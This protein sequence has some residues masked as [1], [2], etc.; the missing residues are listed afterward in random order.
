MNNNK[1][2]WL[3]ILLIFSV[4][5][6]ITTI[7]INQILIKNKEIQNKKQEETLVTITNEVTERLGN[8]FVNT[9][10]IVESNTEIESITF[11]NEDGTNI[12]V[13]TSKLKVAKD[14]RAKLEKEY[15]I[16]VVTKNGIVT[17]KILKIETTIAD[18][19]KVGDFINY[20]VGNWTNADIDLLGNLYSGTSF[21]KKCMNFGGFGVGI[22]KDSSIY[23]TTYKTGWRILSTNSDGS[24]NIMHAGLP[25]SYCWEASNSWDDTDG[26][27]AETL[28]RNTYFKM[29]EDCS[30][31]SVSTQ[32]AIPN[33]AH[34]ITLAEVQSLPENLRA[35]GCPYFLPQKSGDNGRGLYVHS[36]GR[37]YA[38][39]RE[40]YG[41]RVVV[42]LKSNVK[43]LI[44]ENQT[45]HSTP[46]TAW[47]L[48]LS[49]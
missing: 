30:S 26:R 38:I 8:G 3:C 24:V 40:S 28:K 25:M 23:N 11:P 15:P 39:N 16:T 48:N 44:V 21:P 41:I 43:P 46:E 42:M 35:V 13:S 22:S 7:S 14:L 33:S 2:I 36:T 6:I 1:I 4:M 49:E 17:H 27:L 47:N 10:I 29:F 12:K 20:S 32:F 31:D 9:L 18:I 45:T 34:C 5:T 19:V 37:I